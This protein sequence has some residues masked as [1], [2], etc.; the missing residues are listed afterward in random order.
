MQKHIL[1]QNILKNK[2]KLNEKKKFSLIIG[3][4][5][6]QGARSPKLWNRAYKKLKIFKK[7]YPADVDRKNLQ[8]LVN[9]IRSCENF[10]GGSVTMPYKTKIMKF[11]DVI[12]PQAKV[13]GSVNTIK[14]QNNKI[15]ATNTDYEGCLETLKK[16]NININQ[17]ILILGCGG[18]GKACI[19]AV[20]KS[21]RKNKIFLLNRDY[22]K[23]KNFLLKKKLNK[24]KLIRD[25]KKIKNYNFKLIV[26]TTSV[27]FDSW[28][29]SNKGYFNLKYFSPICKNT[30]IKKIKSK[31]P[32]E[33]LKKNYNLIKKNKIETTIF[34]KK[35]KP[36][37]FDI[38]YNPKKT[39]LIKLGNISKKKYK[40]GLQMNLD[41][42]IKGFMYANKIKNFSKV[43][44]AM[45]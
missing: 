24:I 29:K 11:I 41:Q 9:N 25:Y 28:I 33:F 14:R 13:I 19:L 21:F 26:N 23:A 12:E 40:N 22:K 5:P 10:V 31:N 42:A 27:G 15:Y 7:M 43:K 6:S 45:I 1:N 17:N 3:Y 16:F 44:R 4:N 20:L 8:R 32:K 36:D 30:N 34:I 35:N 38:I 37:L 2:I 39:L 18:A